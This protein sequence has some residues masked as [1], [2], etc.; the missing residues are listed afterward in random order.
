MIFQH[1]AIAS[2]ISFRLMNQHSVN[3]PIRLISMCPTMDLLAVCTETDSVWIARWFNSLE[4]IWTLPTG[5]HGNDKVEALTWRP[6]GNNS[7]VVN[8]FNLRF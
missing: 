8:N 3:D 4:K 7:K 2:R 6:D 1:E 5:K